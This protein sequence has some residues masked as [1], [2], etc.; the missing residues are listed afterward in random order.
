[1][2]RRRC[3]MVIKNTYMYIGKNCIGLRPS[4]TPRAP[5]SSAYNH[6]QSVSLVVQLVSGLT[7]C[8]SVLALSLEPAGVISVPSLARRRHRGARR[9]SPLHSRRCWLPISGGCEVAC[10]RVSKSVP[11]PILKYLASFCVR[12]KPPVLKRRRSWGRDS[13]SIISISLTSS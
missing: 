4:G 10:S 9:S 12:V 5:A 3:I 11:S 7:V 6:V 13:Y 2:E 1:M 8:L